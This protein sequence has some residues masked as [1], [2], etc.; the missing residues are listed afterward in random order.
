MRKKGRKRFLSF[1]SPSFIFGSRFISRVAQTGNPVPRSFF[2]LACEEWR[3]CRSTTER[4]S[5][6]RLALLFCAPNQNRHAMQ[7]I[8]TLKPNGNASY[9]GYLLAFKLQRTTNECP[10]KRRIYKRPDQPKY[11]QS[12]H[13]DFCKADRTT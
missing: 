10:A 4:R 3:F 13:T 11:T 12:R 9:E 6:E 7:A 5:C 8:L 1:P 2:A